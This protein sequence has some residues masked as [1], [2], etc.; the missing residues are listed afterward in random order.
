ME[1]KVAI[2][3]E[4]YYRHELIW[5]YNFRL[6][7]MLTLMELRLLTLMLI[8]GELELGAFCRESVKRLY[9]MD[10][11]G[12]KSQNIRNVVNKMEKKGYVIKR[13]GSGN[14]LVSSKFLVEVERGSISE[15]KIK[16]L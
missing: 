3:L 13:K 5:E 4:N 7:K 10:G 11:Y 12:H 2:S 8:W 14:L 9:K 1:R 16:V 15:I 6:G